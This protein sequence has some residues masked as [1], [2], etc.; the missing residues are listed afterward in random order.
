MALT[1]SALDW[2]G[3]LNSSQEIVY[4]CVLDHLSENPSL[5]QFFL[6]GPGGTGKTFLYTTLCICLHS[7][8]KIVLCVV[9]T[10]IAALLLPSG[11][12]THKL[13]KIPIDVDEM[14]SC[15]INR[16][17]HLAELLCQTNLIV[18][19][20]TPMTAKMVFDAVDWILHDICAHLPGGGCPFGGIP[21]ILGGNFQQILP[22]VSK[23]DCTAIVSASPQ[24]TCIWLH[25]ELLTLHENM[26]LADNCDGVN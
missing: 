9:S 19:D 10:G 12:T 6:C 13:F 20:E 1:Q 22:V 18:W 15:F 3:M 2:E 16:C 5:A 11:C 7:Q 17:T 8:G 4:Q 23:G 21:I 24:F 25:L 26:H 14:S